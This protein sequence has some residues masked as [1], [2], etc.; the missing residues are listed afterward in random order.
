MDQTSKSMRLRQ[1]MKFKATQRNSAAKPK[2]TV[3]Y[4][5]LPEEMEEGKGEVLH[6]D[7]AGDDLMLGSALPKVVSSS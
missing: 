4:S 6:T 5:K 7:Q 2:K 3:K 1:S